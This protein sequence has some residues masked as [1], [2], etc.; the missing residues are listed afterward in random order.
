MESNQDPD[1]QENDDVYEDLGDFEE[2]QQIQSNTGLVT[3]ANEHSNDDSRSSSTHAQSPPNTQT[4]GYSSNTSHVTSPSPGSNQHS[5]GGAG[6]ESSVGATTSSS[7]SSR[8]SR[9]SESQNEEVS[10][11]CQ[12]VY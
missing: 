2:I 3:S 1:F 11:D 5:K 8:K 9:K 10:V 4:S 7:G 6:D 12:T